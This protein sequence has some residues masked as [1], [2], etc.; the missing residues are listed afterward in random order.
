VNIGWGQVRLRSRIENNANYQTEL[1]G[2]AFNIRA[3]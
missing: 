1:F 2:D 3:N